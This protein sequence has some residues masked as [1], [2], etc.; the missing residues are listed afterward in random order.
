MASAIDQFH[1]VDTAGAALTLGYEALRGAKPRCQLDLRNV[2]TRLSELP[3]DGQQ[4][5]VV[6]IE[7]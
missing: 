1:C 7:C 4:Q 6:R 5:L 3:Q 2:L